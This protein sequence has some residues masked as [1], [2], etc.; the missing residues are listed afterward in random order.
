[1]PESVANRI[2]E[3]LEEFT[4]ALE[5]GEPIQTKFT[6]RKVEFRL[7]PQP[8]DPQEVKRTRGLLN[9]SQKVFAMFLGTSAKTIQAWEQGTS[10][11]KRMACRF[12]DLIQRDPEYWR[13]VLR[14]QILIKQR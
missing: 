3:R 7:E 1:M 6:C 9:V 14:E 10:P 2:K 8:Y 11:P 4:H 5:S 13:N 12:M